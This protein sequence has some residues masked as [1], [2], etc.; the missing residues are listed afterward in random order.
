MF[1]R[2]YAT[3]IRPIS[4][5]RELIGL[6]DLMATKGTVSNAYAIFL[7]N[8]DLVAF[9]D[10]EQHLVR[11]LIDAATRHCMQ[12]GYPHGDPISVVLQADD[13][14]KSGTFMVKASTQQ[15]FKNPPAETKP[16]IVQESTVQSEP[17]PPIVTP[18]ALAVNAALVLATGQRFELTG[19]SV[20]IGRHESC[21][22]VFA[23]SNVSR[24]HAQLQH[25]LTGWLVV[26]LG[27]TNGV[28]VN[29]TKISKEKLLVDGDELT[30]GTSTAR[31]VTS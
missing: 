28:K 31:F 27:S 4:L 25:D 13:T 6:L 26:D 16:P 1:A 24:V 15:V 17:T 10:V 29:G 19:D 18:K 22:V 11:E 30:F 3:S 5:G 7:N 14:I 20:K 12:L 8:D 23:D 9:A 2:A 21:S